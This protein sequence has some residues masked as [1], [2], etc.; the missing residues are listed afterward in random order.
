MTFFDHYCVDQPVEPVQIFEVGQDATPLLTRGSYQQSDLRTVEDTASFLKNNQN[1]P[2]KCRLVY[3]ES[4]PSLS[5]A[6]N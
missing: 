5:S 1:K 6:N 3:V 2:Y 4:T